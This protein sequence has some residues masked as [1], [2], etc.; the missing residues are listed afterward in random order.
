VLLRSFNGAQGLWKCRGYLPMSMG[1]LLSK[2]V[3]LGDCPFSIQEKFDLISM[4]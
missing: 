4:G 1:K 3:R 2:Q